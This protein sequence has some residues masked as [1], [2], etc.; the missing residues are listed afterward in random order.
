MHFFIQEVRDKENE[1]PLLAEIISYPNE[2]AELFSLSTKTY[3]FW[4]QG[5]SLEEIA[6]IRNLKVATIED[7]FVEIAL[8]EKIFLLKCLWKK[9]R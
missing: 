4:R 1:F 5:R 8:R 9:K 3:N 6:T 7:H 2:R